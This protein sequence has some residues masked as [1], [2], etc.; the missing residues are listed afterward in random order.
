MTLPSVPTA[1]AAVRPT[2]LSHG[3]GRGCKIAPAVLDCF[4]GE[5]FGATAVVAE[6]GAGPAVAASS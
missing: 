5:G 3:G 2:Q 6:L 1:P 4:H